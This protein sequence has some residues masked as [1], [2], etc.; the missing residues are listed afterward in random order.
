[1]PISSAESPLTFWSSL[2][3][4]FTA[5]AQGC[6]KLELGLER[7]VRVR[8]S[9]LRVRVRKLGLRLG[10]G[11]DNSVITLIEVYI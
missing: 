10:F 9:G 2:S 6:K 3:L 4:A 8:R 11:L 7:R 1:M 5:C